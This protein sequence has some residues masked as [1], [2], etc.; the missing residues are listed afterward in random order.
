MDKNTY[1]H[2]DDISVASVEYADIEHAEK[3]AAPGSTPV[4][5]TKNTSE[6]EP[7]INDWNNNGGSGK[8]WSSGSCMTSSV[9]PA[10]LFGVIKARQLARRVKQSRRVMIEPQR[11]VFIGVTGSGKSSVCTALTGQDRK[12]SEFAVGCGQKSKTVDCANLKYRWF[13]DEAEQEFLC[14]DTPGLDDSEGRD[15]AHIHGIIE[16]MR[17]EEYISAII[18]VITDGRFSK[19]LQEVIL[20][21]ETAFCGESADAG[22]DKFYQNVVICFQKWSMNEAAVAVRNEDGITEEG[23]AEGINV[24]LKDKFEHYVKHTQKC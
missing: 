18:L 11:V 20:R 3:F 14:I 10:T 23:R 7:E 8:L 22:Y 13:G 15:E 12:T 2:K 1:K 21:F 19:S 17:N 4:F 6:P 24:Q 5:A 16:A 9:G